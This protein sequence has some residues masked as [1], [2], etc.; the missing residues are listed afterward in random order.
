MKLLIAIV[1]DNDVNLLMDDLV[2]NKFS[3]TKLAT[4]GGFLREGNTTLL[5]GV[6]ENKVDECLELIER[7]CKKRNTTTSFTSSSVQGPMVQS[8][9]VEIEVG[10]ATV[11]ILNVDQF[12]KL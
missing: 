4:T 10:G 1:Q 5:L 7:N 11:F 8:F 2:E 9:P 12:K 6:D 3:V